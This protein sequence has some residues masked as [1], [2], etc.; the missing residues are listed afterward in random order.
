MFNDHLRDLIMSE[1]DGEHEGL[2]HASLVHMAQQELHHL[3]RRQKMSCLW[4]TITY[5]LNAKTQQN[6]RNQII[7]LL[8]IAIILY[9]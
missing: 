4:I 7:S 8:F 5:H 6:F 9:N 1:I 3:Q 2:I